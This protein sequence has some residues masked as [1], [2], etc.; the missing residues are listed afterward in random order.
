MKKLLI[1]LLIAFSLNIS[2]Q[3]K[4]KDFENYAQESF[5]KWDIPSVAIAVVINGK[6]VLQKAYGF[7]NWNKEQKVNKNTLYPIGSVSKSFCTLSLAQLVQEGKISWNTKVKTIIPDFKLYNDY[8]TENATIEDLVCHRIGFKTF[9]G[10]LLWYHTNYSVDEIIQRLQYLKPVYGF[11]NGFG[12]SNVMFLVAGRIVEKI[13]G[14]PYEQYV[15]EHIFEPLEMNRTTMQLSQMQKEGNA[16]VGCYT[17]TKGKKVNCDF[18]PSKNINAFGGINSSVHELANYMIML[19][20]KG[21]FNGK[22]IIDN[23]QIKNLWKMHNSIG[24]SDYMKA[25]HP[26]RHFYGYGL[27]WF[28]F[29]QN[30]YKVVTHDG[31]MD[32]ALCSLL[33]IPETNTGVVILT[34]SSNFLYTALTNYFVDLFTGLKPKDWNDYYLKVYPR[35]WKS[36]VKM[37]EQHEKIKNTKP[38]LYLKNYTGIYKDKMYGNIQITLKDKTLYLHF[39]PTPFLDAKLTHWNY[40]SF[41]IH[42][43]NNL[44]AIPTQWGL[45]NFELNEDGKVSGLKLTVPNYDFLFNELSFKKI[46]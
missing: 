1:L 25:N 9:S 26:S 44:M 6:I 30:G 22:K 34:N 16:A 38:D 12:Y 27:G 19:M 18:I 4:V 21:V 23:T 31:G 32:G 10:D 36:Y 28:L 46:K 20:N 45:A 41:E 43:D 42:F 24:V 2:A 39:I 15:K 5:R 3:N 33:M 13:S 14:M 37:K 29:D 35:Y 17:N 40:N 7:T 8:V 11:R